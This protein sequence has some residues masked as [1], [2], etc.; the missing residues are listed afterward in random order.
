[1]N[2]I[3]YT[4]RKLSGYTGLLSEKIIDNFLIGLNES[5]PALLYMF[6]DRDVKPYRSLLPWSGEF[7]GKYITGMAYMY[8]LTSNEKLYSYA[9][10][11]IEKLLKYQ[12]SDGYLGCF[13]KEGR[14]AGAYVNNIEVGPGEH[15]NWDAW[16]HYH[17][18]YGLI[19]WYDLTANEKYMAAIKKMAEF[20]MSVFYKGKARVIDMGSPGTNLSL[21]HIFGILYGKTGDNRYMKFAKEVE[22]DLASDKAGDYINSALLGYEFYQSREPRWEGLHTVMGI[23]EMYRNTKEAHYLEA[24]KKIFFSILKTDV[25]N[26]GAFSTEE[27]AIG[28]PFENGNIETC[29]VIAYNALAIELYKVTGDIRIIDFLERS[30][31]NAILGYNSPSGRWATYNTPMEGE[32]CASA[33]SINFQ[34]RPGSP[35]LNCCSVNAPRGVA[36][37]ETWMLMENRS[38]V[39]L[40]FYEDME[41]E[42]DNKFKL[43]IKGKY[44]AGNTV[45]INAIKENEDCK[46]ALRIPSWSEQTEITVNGKTEIAAKSEYFIINLKADELALIEIKFDFAYKFENG[47]GEYEGKKSIFRG[48]VLLGLGLGENH[49]F[50]FENLPA[51]FVKDL[52]EAEVIDK[53]YNGIEIKLKSGMILKDFCHLGFDGSKYKTYFEIR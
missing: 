28:N 32:K 46:L 19:L 45:K 50:D 4:K 37:V 9:I 1:M 14:M 52:S 8:K 17:I 20:I 38:T 3:K 2:E 26:T 21:Y 5:N 11:F 7:A 49:N 22:T 43:C 40:N 34:C 36:N 42:T 16:A 6:R 13:N 47:G 51:V 41:I 31:Y 29:C 33:H 48:P 10:D 18:M 24:A 44:P 15:R 53:G 35:E 12:D 23:V 25:H 30:H 39:Y 27:H